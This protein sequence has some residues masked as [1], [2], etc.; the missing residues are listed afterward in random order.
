MWPWVHKMKLDNWWP[1]ALFP[2]GKAIV[3]TSCWSHQLGDTEHSVN[4]SEVSVSRGKTPLAPQSVKWQHFQI[5]GVWKDHTG[6]ADR[7]RVANR[8]RV[9]WFNGIPRGP[10]LHTLPRLRVPSGV[11]AQAT[12]ESLR[13]CPRFL[14][15]WLVCMQCTHLPASAW[16]VHSGLAF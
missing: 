9:S 5:A 8:Q 7:W 13:S 6:M 12:A 14:H 2:E 1:S 4:P 3:N 11:T 10:V 16:C 15:P